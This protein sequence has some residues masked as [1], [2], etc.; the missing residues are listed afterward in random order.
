VLL[1]TSASLL[2]TRAA[3]A[4][5]CTLTRMPDIPV[6]MQGRRPMV[7]AT[8]NGADAVFLADSGSYFNRVT[9]AGVEALHLRLDPTHDLYVERAGGR[10]RIQMAWA[11]TLTLT[12][13]NVSDVPFLVTDSNFGGGA[14]GL[15][16]Q[17][18]LQVTDV[19]YD[20][21]NG[22]IRLARPKDCNG[23]PLAY[24]AGEAGKPYS[25]VDIKFAT[26]DEPHTTGI[27][28]LNG[29]KIRVRVD[30]GTTATVLT[31]EAARRAGITP[32][33]P[34]VVA[35]GTRSDAGLKAY[36]TWI[37]RFASFKFGDEEIQ[38]AQLRFGDIDLPEADMLIGVDF[39]LSHRV[40]L[41]S[42]QRKLY[43][44]YNGGPVFDL[45]AQ[46]APVAGPAAGTMTP[47][48]TAGAAGQ[49][50]PVAAA[51]L[52]PQITARARTSGLRP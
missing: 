5:S 33:S 49:I 40:Y 2:A 25:A 24:W 41:A 23:R 30:T 8:I 50:D 20:L 10:E 51:A 9:R 46:R 45:T 16:G 4:G 48:V 47:Q 27:A 28:Y 26:A 11:K 19:E 21:A 38:H 44:T 32:D 22:V 7:H 43:F 29:T 34:G 6:T 52:E 36:N 17:N 15:F 35:G 37:A 14:I 18:L 1:A 3:Y 12:T 31:L 39:F 13:L 42:S